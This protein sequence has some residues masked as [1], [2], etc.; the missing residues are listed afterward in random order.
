MARMGGVSPV[1]GGLSGGDSR[2]LE[3]S[4]QG[5]SSESPKAVA[6][7]QLPYVYDYCSDSLHI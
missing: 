3:Q 5:I 6:G 4:S 2:G 1:K 7:M